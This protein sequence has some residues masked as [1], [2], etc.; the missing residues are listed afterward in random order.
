MPVVAALLAYLLGSLSFGILYSRLRGRDV[1]QVDAPGGSGIYRQYGLGPAIL[2]TVLDILK[3]AAAVAVA[4]S[5]APGAVW[6]AVAAVILGHNYPVFFR[7]DGGGGIAPLLGAL[8]L[9]APLPITAMVVVGLLFMPIYKATLQQRL[10][11]NVI[12]AA[13]ALAVP[14]GLAVAARTADVPEVA[15]GILAMAVRAIH[16]LRQPGG[17]E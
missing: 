2:V 17:K 16:L 11:F 1:R 10:K 3:G 12:P 4:Q 7:F 5:I 15:S 14:V 8:A 9:C 6:L 13:T